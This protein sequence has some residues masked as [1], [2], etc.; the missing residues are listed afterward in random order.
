MAKLLGAVKPGECQPPIKRVAIPPGWE[1]IKETIHRASLCFGSDLV[2]QFDVD[3]LHL[4][5]SDG[6][7]L[8]FCG[9]RLGVP[10]VER[11]LVDVCLVRM[12]ERHE[13][14]TRSK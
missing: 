13:G 4:F 5:D 1:R 9:S 3:D 14:E 11:E 7:R 10:G 8:E 12:V 2:H 6:G